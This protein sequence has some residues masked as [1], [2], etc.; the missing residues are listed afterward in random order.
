MKLE[1]K[2]G[3]IKYRRVVLESNPD[4]IGEKVLVE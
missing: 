3:E 4:G 1:K 2:A